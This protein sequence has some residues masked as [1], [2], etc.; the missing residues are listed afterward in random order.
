MYIFCNRPE[1]DV[2]VITNS[3]HGKKEILAKELL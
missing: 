2:R 1:K 3:S